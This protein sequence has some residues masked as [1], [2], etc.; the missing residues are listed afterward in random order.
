M[1]RNYYPESFSQSMNRYGRDNANLMCG[2]WFGKVTMGDSGA[3]SPRKPRTLTGHLAP[4]GRQTRAPSTRRK[5][6]RRRASGSGSHGKGG[7]YSASRCDTIGPHGAGPN[8]HDISHKD[9][10]HRVSRLNCQDHRQRSGPLDG[11]FDYHGL[12]R[13]ERHPRVLAGKYLAPSCLD[14]SLFGVGRE[15]TDT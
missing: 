14:R 3:R 2:R 12:T 4:R 10:N 6:P 9:T 7:R 11:G 5:K 13:A 1:M 8:R 15:T